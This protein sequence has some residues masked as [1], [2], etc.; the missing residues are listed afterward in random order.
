MRIKPLIISVVFILFAIASGTLNAADNAALK[1]IE[2]LTGGGF[3]QLHFIIDKMISIPYIAPEKSDN[4]LI[5]MKIKDVPVEISKD[6]FTFDSPI[7]DSIDVIRGKS[8]SEAEFKIR[9][10]KAINYRVFS[11]SKGLFIEFESGGLTASNQSTPK[12][13]KPQQEPTHIAKTETPTPAPSKP[14]EPLPT[15]TEKVAVNTG[16]DSGKNIRINDV[17]VRESNEDHIK[18]EIVL[19]GKPDYT[20]IP[21]PQDPARLAIDFKNTHAKQIKKSINQ[22]NVKGVRGG[23]NSSSV[24]RV[25]FDLNY[26]KNYTVTPITQGGLNILEVDFTAKENDKSESLAKVTPEPEPI[27]PTIEKE[28]KTEPIP[29]ATE[30]TPPPVTVTPTVKTDTTEKEAKPAQSPTPRPTTITNDAPPQI[31]IKNEDFFADEKSQVSTKETP[32][33]QP[34]KP[35]T[36]T[37]EDKSPSVSFEKKT[38]DVGGKVYTGDR[39]TFN[40]HDSELKDVINFISKMANRNIVMDPSITGR[41]NSR[42]TDVPWDQALELFLKINGLGYVEEGSI[43]RVGRIEQLSREAAEQ[44]KLREAQQQEGELTVV[45]RTMSYSKVTEVATLLKNQ[46]SERGEIL[47]DQRTNTM[48]ISDVR[49]RID[50]IDKLIDNFDMATPQVSIEARFVET[51]SNFSQN[52]GIQWGY[53]FIADSAYG[54]Q[55]T[56]KFPNSIKIDGTQL[57]GYAVNLPAGS[58]Y[59]ATSFSLGNVA[60]TFKLNVALS[61]L[62]SKGEVRVISAPKATTQNNKEA[63]ITQGSEVPFLMEQNN[64]IT[65]AYKAAALELKVTPQITAKGTIICELDIKNNAPDY[66][67]KIEKLGVPIITQAVR[68]T[69]MVEDGGTIVV[70]GIYQGQNSTTKDGIPFFSKIPILGTLFKRSSKTNSQKELLVFITP[71]I[72]K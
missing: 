68:T 47:V 48:V 54:N 67:N 61:A 33:K 6:R 56:L 19:T 30:T 26:L 21:I 40:F 10:K 11:N 14:V 59:G 22:L 36:E 52:L 35:K 63:Y 23:L 38:I 29:T 41:I 25:V 15:P 43:I 2:Y 64:T 51:R 28:N 69:V 16:K 7:I 55:T 5:V 8:S 34:E 71:R 62:E 65:V 4:T 44:R 72:V 31:K 60:N 70:G 27:S 9:L 32:K 39:M 58:S 12:T 53:N 13:A 49:S 50:K 3:V 17:I 20:V 18:F 1:N 57:G 66:A 46:L 37:P 42:L 24:Y 45:T